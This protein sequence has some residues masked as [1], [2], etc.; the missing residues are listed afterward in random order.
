MREEYYYA[1]TM[2]N[3]LRSFIVMGWNMEV[4]RHSNDAWDWSKIEGKRTQLEPSQLELLAGW[5]CGRD[6]KEIMNTLR[7]MIPE[8]RRLHTILRG[9][10]GL[11]IDNNH[12]ERV[13]TKFFKQF[14][15]VKG[16]G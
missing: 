8:I 9:K 12:F 2:I 5:S 6:Q 14:E 16:I 4:D 13:I 10:T 1:L 3:N 11:K 7:V 15:E